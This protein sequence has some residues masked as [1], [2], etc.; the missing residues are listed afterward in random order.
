MNGMENE[1]LNDF[2][3]SLE[4]IDFNSYNPNSTEFKTALFLGL[5]WKVLSEIS[6]EDDDEISEELKGSKK[7]LQKYLDT[8]D[9][10]YRKMA[11]DELNHANFLIKKENSKMLSNEQKSKL[12]HYQNVSEQIKEILG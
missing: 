12:K 7:Y 2:K 10:Q 3:K 6:E 11:E 4:K 9:S 5:M 1:I 8:N